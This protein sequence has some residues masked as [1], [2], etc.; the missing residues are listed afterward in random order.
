MIEL[1]GYYPD[2]IRIVRWLGQA[3]KIKAQVGFVLAN[4]ICFAIYDVE[5]PDM[6]ITTKLSKTLLYK[7]GQTNVG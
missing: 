4:K 2:S 7:Q 3:L 5:E 6:I 1:S